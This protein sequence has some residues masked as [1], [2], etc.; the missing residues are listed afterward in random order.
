MDHS[1]QYHASQ[2]DGLSLPNV[3]DYDGQ[4]V[5]KFSGNVFEQRYQIVKKTLFN[6]IELNK[7]DINFP[8]PSLHPFYRV[9]FP[10]SYFT[11]HK[12]K[13]AHYEVTFLNAVFHRVDIFLEMQ[14]ITNSVG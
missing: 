9:A 2:Y 8:V 7:K 13:F 11:S 10:C 3:S 1:S 14:K 4:N 5:P 12:E 6:S